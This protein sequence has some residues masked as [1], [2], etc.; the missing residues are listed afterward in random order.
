[1]AKAFNVVLKLRYFAKSGHT[2][3]EKTKLMK[4]G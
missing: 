1:M 3:K 4:V 2:E